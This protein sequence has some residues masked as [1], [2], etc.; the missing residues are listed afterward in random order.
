[1]NKILLIAKWEVFRSK[2]RFSFRTLVLF[3]LLSVLMLLFFFKTLGSE[4]KVSGEI[5][6]AALI[7]DDKILQNAIAYDGRFKIIATNED[8]AFSLLQ[9]GKL[10]LVIVSRGR[11]TAIYSS[12]RDRAAGALNAL[13]QS[14]K[15]YK[16]EMIWYVA[17]EDISSAFPLWV[18]THYLRREQE[19]Q[20]TTLGARR[21]ES[22][23]IPK[24]IEGLMPQPFDEVAQERRLAEIREGMFKGEKISALVGKSIV[25]LPSLM[26]P[27]LPLHST[28]L[29]FLFALPL[30]LF[31]QLYS[32]S[33]MEERVNKR[34][35][36]LLASPLKRREI[37][38]GKTLL[39]FVLAL[40]AI[41]II[42]LALKKTLD[43]VI[44][45]LLVPVLLFFL[46]LSFFA[47]MISRSFK[48]NSFIVIFLSV[49]FFGYL[50]FPSMF[51]N[52]HVASS[53]SPITFVI[54]RLEGEAVTFGE[55]TFATLPLY[56]SST[57]IFFFC[58]F[59]FREE[60][61]FSQASMQERFCDIVEE[62]WKA[63]GRSSFSVFLLSIFFVPIVYL[64][65]LMFL[66]LLF[67]VPYPISVA[68]M[69][70]LSALTEEVMK[71][72][73]IAALS[74]RYS[75][76]PIKLVFY[77]VLSG[78]GFFL[79]EKVLAFLT[80][81]Q[82][83]N[84]LFGAAM[85]MKTY[86]FAALGLHVAFALVSSIGLIWSK[87]KANIRFFAFLLLA[88]ALHAAYNASLLGWLR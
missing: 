49:A 9:R 50:F 61:L 12:K 42:S 78:T 77:A 76:R 48:E 16:L 37:I 46:A 85:F 23:N 65:Q 70:L 17:Q 44:V 5:Y 14:V 62:Y 3:A 34:A 56:M 73:G 25:T 20:Y 21:V 31:S 35:E 24:E 69:L 83:T 7:G 87:G 59:L 27:P 38:L 32:S 10:D 26:S 52:I 29:T 84:S 51:A 58:T 57:V 80:L 68:G 1:M 54:K 63:F 13:D 41:L 74:A 22:A 71:I 75:L 67:Q 79:G 6:A 19:F 28:L 82:I 60:S 40:L 81:A 8:A 43:L 36:L 53:I 30:Y 2:A 11:A 72:S 4:T 66:V 47:A 55:Y 15:R 33:M 88:A 45:F 39:H 64:A 86:L 18:Q